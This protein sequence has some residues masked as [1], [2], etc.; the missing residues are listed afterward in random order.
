APQAPARK[1][2][3][4]RAQPSAR[5]TRCGQERSPGPGRS[6]L[7][8]VSVSFIKDCPA[9]S[10]RATLERVLQDSTDYCDSEQSVLSEFP[11]QDLG[12]EGLHD[13]VVGAGA[14]GARDMAG[15]AFDRA[16]EHLGAAAARQFAQFAHELEPVHLGHAPV[17]ENDVRHGFWH[18]ASAS[19]PLS[20]SAVRKWKVSKMRRATRRMTA[21]SST[22]KI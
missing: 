8:S 10:A 12:V 3:P 6:K 19:A 2:R 14:L 17:D 11:A 20:A 4:R 16:I 9:E 15:V 22:I 7:S 18:S 1:A 13:V 5:M 21:L